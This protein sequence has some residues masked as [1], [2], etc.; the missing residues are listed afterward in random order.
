MDRGAAAREKNGANNL[1]TNDRDNQA[2][3][4]IPQSNPNHQKKALPG[5]GA[6]RVRK[7]SPGGP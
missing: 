7:N 4:P 1:A 2:P 6:N 5:F 3:E